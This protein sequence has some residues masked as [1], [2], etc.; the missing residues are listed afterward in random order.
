MRMLLA[1][2]ALMTTASAWALPVY[3][4]DVTATPKRPLWGQ[5]TPWTKKLLLS[6]AFTNTVS[7][8]TTTLELRVNA[9]GVLSGSVNGQPDFIIKGDVHNGTFESAYDTGTIVCDSEVDLAFVLQNKSWKQYF[10]ID[11]FIS[12]GHILNRAD[13]NSIDYGLLCFKGDVNAVNEQ[14]S[15]GFG[16]IGKIVDQYQ[17]DFT[18]EAEDCVEW[19]G[20]NPDD[21]ECLRYQRNKRTKPV[22]DCAG[23]PDPRS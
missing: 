1:L 22:M 5:V 9:G 10:T 11:P 19:R 14:L 20:T 15:L 4:C 21:S 7:F 3:N 18:W 23:R 17:I 8:N 2:L 13:L 12:Q 6:P 16:V